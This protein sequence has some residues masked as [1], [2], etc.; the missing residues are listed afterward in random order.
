MIVVL[1]L[2]VESEETDREKKKQKAER[3]TMWKKKSGNSFVV[4]YRGKG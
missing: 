3:Q 1:T 2:V 4:D